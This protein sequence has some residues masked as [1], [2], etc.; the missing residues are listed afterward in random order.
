MDPNTEPLECLEHGSDCAGAVEYRYPLSGTGIP[1]PR[2]DH[3]WDLRLD[4]HERDTARLP[5]SPCPPEWYDES[6]CGEAWDE[7]AA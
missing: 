6:A 4:R 3:H 2:C 5:D 7:E 1:F